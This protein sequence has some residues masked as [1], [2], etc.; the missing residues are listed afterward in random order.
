MKSVILTGLLFVLLCVDHMSSA[1]QSVVATQ[2]IPINTAL[3]LV[4]MTTRVIYPTGIPAE[5]IPRLVSM[6]VN[7]AVPMGTTLM[8][9]M[10]KFY[11]LCAPKN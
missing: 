3:T 8:P 4:M 5:D 7:Q 10:V 6:Q 9:D 2:L 1:N 11:C